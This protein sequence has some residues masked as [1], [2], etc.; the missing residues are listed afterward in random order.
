MPPFFPTPA[1]GWAFL[2]LL[3][4][5]L[6]VACVIDLRSWTLPKKLTLAVLPLGLAANAARGAWLGSAGSPV[7]AFGPAG[8]F[9]GAADGLLFGLAGFAAAFGLFFLLWTTG[10]CGGGDVK[11]AAGL[12]A[13]IGPKLCLGLL[14]GTV[15]VVAG[16][17]VAAGVLRAVR[18][19][20]PTADRR[21]VNF[22]VPVTLVLLAMLPWAFRADLG[23]TRPTA[24]PAEVARHAR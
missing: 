19:T 15:A 6:A 9:G 14:A 17:V 1:F 3:F 24:A 23:L 20:P 16:W 22:S 21:W 10:T 8:S 12:G 13:W 2:F 11:L 4:V 7:W 18:R 5:L